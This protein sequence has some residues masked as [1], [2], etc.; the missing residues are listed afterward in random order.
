MID[1]LKFLIL[2]DVATKVFI[3]S[4]LVYIAIFSINNYFKI[5][6]GTKLARAILSLASLIRHTSCSV[7]HVL[8]TIVATIIIMAYFEKYPM[9][10][11]MQ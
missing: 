11:H 9:A 4:Y 10:Y 5:F 8:T 1:T 7:I 2:E 6:Q 3:E